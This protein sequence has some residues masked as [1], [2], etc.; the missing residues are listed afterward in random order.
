MT[1]VITGDVINSRME[2]ASEWLP[3][4]KGVLNQYGSTP[5]QWEI[6]RGD[7]FQ[8]ELEPEEALRAAMHIKTG[9]KQATHLDV[10]IAIGIGEKTH[11]A[12]KI[13]ESNGSA[14]VH[15][16]ECFETLK[17]QTLAIKSPNPE[18][19]ETI[20]LLLALALLTMNNWST[21]TSLAVKTALENPQKNQKELAALLSKSQSNISET[22]K[23]A[24][25]EEIT[26]LEEKYRTLIK[27]L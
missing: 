14:F 27:R 17:K 8:L 5:S 10:R 2:K 21:V 22:L 12:K 24:G 18:L 6:F 13:T 20:N 3:L 19:D 11:Q 15:S 16:G 25:F 4:L 9:V 1:A 23:R 7:S 26:R